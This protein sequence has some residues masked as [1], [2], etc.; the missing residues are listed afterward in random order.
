MATANL[1]RLLKASILLMFVAAAA[2]ARA[3]RFDEGDIRGD[4]VFTFDG[5]AGTAP[6]AA[7]GRF[8][9]DGRGNLLNGS[10]TLVVAGAKYEQTLTCTYTV[11]PDGSGTATCPVDGNGTETFSFVLFKHGDETYLVGTTAGFTVHGNAIRQ[12]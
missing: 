10:R 11:D 6:V 5:S 9:G 12:K 2:E 7:V 4:Y 1:H 3:D 8:V